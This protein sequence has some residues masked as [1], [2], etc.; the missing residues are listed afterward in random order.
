MGEADPTIKTRIIE[1]FDRFAGSYD[2]N[3]ELQASVAETL[4]DGARHLDSR[5]SILDIGCGT[6]HVALRAA[7]LWPQAHI[8]ALDAAP[9]MLGVVHKKAPNLRILHSDAANIRLDE[10]FDLV[11][12]SMML[13]W[14][15]EP[16]QMASRWRDL[17]APGGR[18]LVA[19]P[20]QGSLEEWRRVCAQSGITDPTWTFP[21]ETFLDGVATTR[22]I[23]EHPVRYASLLAFL[24]SMKKIGATTANPEA[25]RIATTALRRVIKGNSGAFVSTFRVLYAEIAPL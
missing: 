3:S 25:P 18:L 2:A 20:V 22:R 15:D 24:D 21:A 23:V 16:T 14:L 19:A 8:T 13:H 5:S 10:K 6:G 1:T 17:L 9:G 12:S 7:R 11:F 4:L